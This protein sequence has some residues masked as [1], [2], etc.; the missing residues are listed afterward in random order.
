MAATHGSELVAENL[1]G[2]APPHGELNAVYEVAPTGDGA[3]LLVTQPDS[4]ILRVQIA[5]RK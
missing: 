3:F 1:A 4:T 2:A 5:P